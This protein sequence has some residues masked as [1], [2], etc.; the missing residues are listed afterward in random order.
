MRA[1]VLSLAFFGMTTYLLAQAPSDA[2]ATLRASARLV[3]VDVVVEDAHGHPIKGLKQSDF[4]LT[5]GKTEQIV[6]GFEEHT[7]PTS[8]RLAP[9]PVL[10]P[11]VFTNYAPAPVGSAVNVLLLDLLNTP[12]ADQTY[13]RSQLVKYLQTVK[14]GTRIAIFSLTDHLRL[15]QS[16]TTDPE[17][18]LRTIQSMKSRSSP[19]LE[20]PGGSGAPR[21]IAAQYGEVSLTPD[22]P[23]FVL[24]VADF[25]A[26]NKS[27]QTSSRAYD[28]YNALNTLARYLVSIPGRKNLLWFSGSFPVNVMPDADAQG[29]PFAGLAKTESGF[30]ETTNLLT[31]AQVA[32]YPIDALGIRTRE[33]T[34]ASAGDSSA[35]GG[36]KYLTD[37]LLPNDRAFNQSTFDDHATMKQLAQDT[38]GRAFIN[39]NG[40][41]LAAAQATEDGSSYYTLSYSPSDTNQN[42]TYRAI[43]VKLS[44]SGAHLYYRHGYYAEQPSSGKSAAAAPTPGK[45]MT[46]SLFGAPPSTQ[47]IFN[48]FVQP[49]GNGPEDKPAAGNMVAAGGEHNDKGWLRYSVNVAA[50]THAMSFLETPQGRFKDAVEFLT[51]VYTLDGKLV[52]SA[53]ATTNADVA[54]A[55]YK[56]LL[57]SGLHVA[58]QVSVP[59]KGQFALRIVVRDRGS[60]AIG[61]VEIPVSAVHRID[62]KAAQ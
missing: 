36:D 32:V 35:A 25:E 37:G 41:A 14:P 5:E 48:T 33:T 54:A 30:Q 51:L 43:R 29:S 3:V 2:I 53:I 16:F 6:R 17:L 58:Q 55:E 56:Q 15:L 62:V 57:K 46:A 8:V 59:A 44:Q 1:R 19:L 22:T 26:E 7:A 12:M 40:L 47:I 20:D 45:L 50:D 52:N 42:G 21:S 49:A 11:G 61:S 24:N 39:T 23:S 9:A 4:I 13:V 31:R 18:L 27:F 60:N 28:T 10:P 38:G 34:L